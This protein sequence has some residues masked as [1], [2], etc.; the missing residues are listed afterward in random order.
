MSTH[1]LLRYR[2][3]WRHAAFML[4]AWPAQIV[5]FLG[6]VVLLSLGLGTAVIT[7]GIPVM[8]LGLRVSSSLASRER[9]IV[10]QADGT[11]YPDSYRVAEP[12]RSWLRRH[13]TVLSDPQ[14]WLDALWLLLGATLGGIPWS[15]ALAVVLTPVGALLET[16]GLS[17]IRS[18]G[19]TGLAGQIGLPPTLAW[20]ALVDLVVIVVMAVAGPPVL[21]SLARA[22]VSVSRALLCAPGRVERLETSRAAIQR[23]EAD[24]RTRLERDI[25]DG[26][27]QSLVR[28]G[29]DLALA[30]RRARTNPEA[31]EGLLDSAITQTRQ[32]LNELR[33]L[34]R[35]IAPPV[36]V[37]RGL[38][39]AL[40]EVAARSCVPVTVHTTVPR[41]PDHIEQAAYFVAS[42][43]LTNVNKHS[44]ATSA[45]L[46]ATVTD[47]RLRVWVRDNGAGGAEQSK[48]HGLAGLAERLQGVDGRLVVISPP[49][50]PTTVEGVIPCVS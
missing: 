39:A 42:E 1:S 10:A 5:V 6:V 19:G 37:D 8:A 18:W 46:G 36:L 24:T 20:T 14:R 30:K 35:G 9:S 41:L 29:M 23:A 38:A 34:S 11:D 31:A 3:A 33:A 21:R 32:T 40:S 12:G 13:L 16:L 43:A 15:A 28:L 47:G 27:Q 49:G 17:V 26:P 22:R 44:G 4:T 7:V 45:E 48:G 50:G 25:H 2:Q